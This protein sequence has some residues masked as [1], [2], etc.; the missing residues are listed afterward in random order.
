VWAAATDNPAWLALA[1]RC[2]ALMQ[3]D[4]DIAAKHFTM[5]LEHHQ[6]ARGEFERARTQLLYG[7]ELRRTRRPAAAREHLRLAA[8]TFRRYRAIGLAEQAEAELRAAGD[9]V[10]PAAGSM[11][12]VLTAQQLQIARLAAAGSTNR[13]VAAALFLSTRTVD[14]H[15]RNILTRLGVRSRVDLVRLFS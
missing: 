15:M 1:E 9:H 13:E 11:V 8:E 12:G 3:E 6:A 10:S 7:Q 5:A 4:P 14:Y 2:Q